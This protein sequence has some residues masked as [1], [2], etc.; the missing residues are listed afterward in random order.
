MSPY[1]L[2]MFTVMINSIIGGVVLQGKRGVWIKVP[3]ELVNLVEPAV[4]VSVFAL[5]QS[6]WLVFCRSL[7]FMLDK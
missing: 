2:S 7:K 3:I 4:K 5:L 1:E 6:S